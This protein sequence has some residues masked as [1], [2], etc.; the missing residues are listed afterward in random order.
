MNLIENLPEERHP[1]AV[2]RTVLAILARWD[3]AAAEQATIL[4]LTQEQYL[5]WKEA[6]PPL[7]SLDTATVLRMSYVLGIYAALQVLYSE[8]WAADAWLKRSNSDPTFGGQRPLDR[9]L[10]GHLDDFAAVRRFL[11]GW[12]E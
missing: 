7:T 9:L 2:A 5:A 6:P 10:K 11:D 8:Q 1:G 3:L 4:G 12:T